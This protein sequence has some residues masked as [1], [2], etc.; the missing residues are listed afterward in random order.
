M[1]RRAVRRVLLL[2]SKLAA[3]G[4]ALAA[5]LDAGSTLEGRF[6]LEAVELT[7]RPVGLKGVYSSSLTLRRFLDRS[8]C[9]CVCGAAAEAGGRIFVAV[10][11]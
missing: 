8:S 4:G 2:A 10:E 3:S 9:G 5:G 1:G 7:G 11:A 6:E